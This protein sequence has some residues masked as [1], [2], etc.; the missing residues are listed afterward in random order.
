MKILHIHQDFPDGRPFPHTKAVHHLIKAAQQ[1]DAS[2]MHF[3]LSVNR[4]SN[5]FKISFK[6]FKQGVSIVYWAIPLPFLYAPSLFFWAWLIARKL[7]RCEFTAVHGHKLTSEGVLA[8]R[9]SKA[10][11]IPYLV[12][13]R[14]GSDLHNINR[15]IDCK[16]LFSKVYQ[17]AAFVFWVSPWAKASVE[18]KLGVERA[19]KQARFANI[20]Q[21]DP[22]LKSLPVERS[23]YLTVLSFHQYQRKGIMPLIEAISELKQAGTQIELNICGGG[24]ESV[25]QQ[26]VE[27]IQSLNLENQVKLLGQLP[28]DQLLQLMKKSKGF[29]LPAQNETFGMAYI[30]AL[31][32][33]CPILYHQNTGVDGFF[34]AFA[35]GVK[36]PE[37]S[38][39]ELFVALRQFEVQYPLYQANVQKLIDEGYLKE[40]TADYA[41]NHYLTH[42][43]QVV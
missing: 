2:T 1:Q 14:G 12:S 9:L 40:F 3:V 7:K 5:P 33:G 37:Q 21:I 20:C 43:K 30:E 28:H 32:C 34:D 24:S 27:L 41:A 18:Q 22:Q 42:L 13:V 6:T 36:V 4:T 39:G 29:L 15:L 38:I 16:K 17:Q 26:L 23:Q 11:K 19:N 8:Y 35:P 10:W 31:S 25:K